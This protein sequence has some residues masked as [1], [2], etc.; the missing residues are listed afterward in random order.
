MKFQRQTDGVLQTEV[1]S[2]L[3]LLDP[4]SNT[5]FL[6]NRTGAVIWQKLEQEA[7]LDEIC[8][9]V[10]GQFDIT[11]EV[12]REDVKSLLAAIKDKG[13]LITHDEGSV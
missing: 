5:Y 13:F 9:E 6:L 11:A 7:T 3:A 10:A 1:D 4:N 2:G 8:A 12:C